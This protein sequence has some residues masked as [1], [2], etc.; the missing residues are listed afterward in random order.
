M[1]SAARPAA[2][3]NVTAPNILLLLIDDM[4]YSDLA[5]FGSRNHSTPH[6]D[7]LVGAG[8]KFTHWTSGASICTPSRASLQTGRYPIRTGCIGNV[9]QF[10]VV[11]TPTSPHG[12]DPSKQASLARARSRS[13]HIAAHRRTS[14][15]APGSAGT[16]ERGAP[17]AECSRPARGVG[18]HCPRPAKGASRPTSLGHST[19]SGLAAPLQVSLAN[20]LKRGANYATGTCSTL[21]HRRGQSPQPCLRF[22]YLL[23]S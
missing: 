6:I 16:R 18:P 4:G 14:P 3:G 23:A 19:D 17:G 8:M 7:A 5:A 2:M 20:A 9:E 21:P 22:A 15:H 13:P 12:L 10:R 11:P 1:L